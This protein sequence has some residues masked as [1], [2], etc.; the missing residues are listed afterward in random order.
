MAKI[1]VIGLGYVGLPLAALCA[2][3]EYDVIGLERSPEVV[4]TLKTGKSHIIDHEVELLLKDAHLSGHFFPTTDHAELSACQTYL[5]CVPTPVDENL[6]P[7]LE[8]LLGAIIDIA[9][10]INKGDLIVVESTIF[11]GT[12]ESIVLPLL[13]EKTGLSVGND[14]HLAH[15][16]E[17]VNPGDSFWTSANIPRVVGATTAEGTKAAAQFYSSILGGEILNVQDIRKSLRPKFSKTEDGYTESQI[18]LGSV[19][20]MRSIRDAEAVK[21]MENTVRDVNIAFVNELAKISDALELDVVDVIDGMTTK[22]FGKGPFFP[23]VGVGGHCIAV[24]PEWLKAASM[25]A[26]YMPEIIQLSRNTNNGMPAYTIRLLQDALND[27]GYP[28]NGTE[29]A[30]LGVAYKKNID[31]PRESPFY[32]VKSQLLA[33]GAKLKVYDGW[34]KHENSVDSLEE[35]LSGVKAVLIVTDHD[36]YITRVKQTNLAD[37]GIEIIIDGR[38]CLD[39]E[40]ISEQGITYIGV[41]RR[42]DLSAR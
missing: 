22:P 17:R 33:K 7:D 6:E 25:K 10:H 41:G 42:A 37:L 23:G 9:P 30:V 11:P 35:A 27:R 36:D 12:C 28:V 5:I 34:V 40:A 38:N 15:C 14:I 29:I 1:A 2:I 26:G 32:E 18:P 8:P 20:M 4:E 13:E 31:D 21:A 24:D 16:P 39:G 19:T 3:K